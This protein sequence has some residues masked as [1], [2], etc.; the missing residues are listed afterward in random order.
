MIWQQRKG[1]RCNYSYFDWI[2]RKSTKKFPEII[3]FI[4]L[5]NTRTQH[6]HTSLLLLLFMPTPPSLTALNTLRCALFLRSSLLIRSA[7][8]LALERSFT[9]DLFPHHTYIL[10]PLSNKNTW[11]WSSDLALSGT[12]QWDVRCIVHVCLLPCMAH[13]GSKCSPF[14]VERTWYNRTGYSC[15]TNNISI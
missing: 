2:I 9:R 12:W 1:D 13:T 15:A 7:I 11:V 10:R 14:L 4:I 6:I 5:S 8:S 3:W